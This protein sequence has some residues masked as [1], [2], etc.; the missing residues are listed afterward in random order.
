MRRSIHILF[1][2]LYLLCIGFSI[3]S[4]KESHF[5]FDSN[6][7]T[8]LDETVDPD[9]YKLGPGDELS[10]TMITS[11]SVI[12][13]RL[14][15]SYLGDIVIPSIGKVNIDKMTLSKAFNLIREKCSDK[16]ENSSIDLTLS[17]IKNFKTLVLAPVNIPSGYFSVKSSTRLLDIFNQLNDMYTD[18]MYASINKISSR[19]VIIKSQD[20]ITAYDL[21]SFKA[22]GE[23][24]ENPYIMP[25]DVIE[26]DYLRESIE[27]HGA[28]MNPGVYEYKKGET[29]EKIMHITGG[30][31]K[32][33]DLSN[34]EITRYNSNIDKEII[35]V[36]TQDFSSFQLMPSDEILI[37]SITDYKV[38]KY[39][40]ISGEIKNPGRYTINANSTIKDII[41]RSG[42]YSINA[43][44]LKIILNNEVINNIGDREL[45][46]ILALDSESRSDLDNSY[47]RARARSDRG[48]I[49][50]A[51][52]NI[53]SSLMSNYK[54]FD[55]DVI[56]IPKKYDFI[57]VIGAVRNPGRYPFILTTGIKEYIEMAGGVTGN[58][59]NKYYIIQSGTGDR[60]YYK[61]FSGDLN[62][63]DIIFV[64]ERN[65]YNSFDRFKDVVQIS[66][67]IITILAII[68]N[69]TN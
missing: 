40:T 65:D 24:K 47:V 29:F 44:S 28:V 23:K 32:N 9:I 4:S 60:V 58:S 49:S 34:V 52:F 16:I 3:E 69:L 8:L 21:L 63:Q 56:Y 6:G 18:S 68:N 41:E 1:L 13:E 11:N 25:G 50:N 19:N 42:G 43:D 22:N 51:D 36:D 45:N 38:Q 30:F 31:Q 54:L 10:F 35:Y 48:G 62:S 64:E 55:K 46:R 14:V 15:V 53:E 2:S 17:K 12:N 33:A 59:T 39:V 67:Q 27:I 20:K 5:I 57:E 66:S 61:D 37:K 7:T 26:L